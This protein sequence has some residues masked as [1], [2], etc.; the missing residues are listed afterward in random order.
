M[1]YRMYRTGF[2]LGFG[3]GMTPVVRK[4]LIANVAVFVA[5]ILGQAVGLG[6]LFRLFMLTPLSVTHGFAVW[7]LA[8]YMF[9]HAGFW[10]ILLNMF[11]L[12]MFG[13][14]LERTWGS[15]RFLRYYFLTGVGAGVTIVLLGPFSPIPTVGASGAVY[16]I[17][18]A[19]GV[20]F[21]NRIILVP[22]FF[23]FFVPVPAKY[24]V[25][26]LGGIAFLSTLSS[27]GDMISHTG[28][29]GGM[30]FG[31]IYLRGRPYW[32]ELR[33]RYYRWRQQRRRRQFEVYMRRRG[34]HYEPPEQ[35]ER[36]E[37]E[38]PRRGPWVN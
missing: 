34:R 21:P 19:Y 3:Y 35:R 17:L 38:D 15:R 25:M 7:Q 10:H 20:L 13:C 14:E 2:D 31:L 27:P 26:I 4:L 1:T 37:R 6:A 12:W 22:I 29:L 23:F 9:L 8:T 24:L 11:G 16:G 30:I 28:H 36:S 18:L 5:S 33:N 32:F